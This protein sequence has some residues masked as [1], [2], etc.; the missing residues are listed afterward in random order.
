[1]S[2]GFIQNQ[3]KIVKHNHI[4][5]EISNVRT[6]ETRYVFPVILNMFSILSTIFIVISHIFF[7]LYDNVL[8]FIFFLPFS[9]SFLNIFFILPCTPTW[10]YTLTSF[11]YYILLNT[12]FIIS[13]LYLNVIINYFVAFCIAFFILICLLPLK[14]K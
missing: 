9:L 14:K 7:N 10:S 6:T 13:F 8:I 5:N 2:L 4:E 1:M 12:I 3:I 11:P